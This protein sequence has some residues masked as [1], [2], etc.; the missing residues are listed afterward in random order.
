MKR[1]PTRPPPATP[2]GVAAL[3][4][5]RH[6][7]G[8]RH[9]EPCALQ[10]GRARRQGHL[11][12][13][14]TEFGRRQDQPAR[15]SRRARGV[16]RG[17]AA[18]AARSRGA[19]PGHAVHRQRRLRALRGRASVAAPARRAVQR[20]A[21]HGTRRQ[22]SAAAPVRRPRCADADD[23]RPGAA[24]SGHAGLGPVPR[25]RRLSARVAPAAGLPVPGGDADHRA[26][27]S[28]APRVAP[29]PAAPVA[30]AAP[31]AAPAPAPGSI[32]F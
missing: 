8:A 19:L 12:R 16:D 29:R 2:P 32:R 10:G 5:A 6:G 4:G 27:R 24:R 31:V 9:V 20:E 22:R 14:R 28:R 13:P 23:R 3:A 26:S 21:G 15:R 18:R 17:P 11:H 25:L 30:D 7:P 1:R